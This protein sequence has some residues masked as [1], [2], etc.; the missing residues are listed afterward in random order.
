MVGEL[1][2]QDQSGRDTQPWRLEKLKLEGMS[3]PHHSLPERKVADS[4]AVVFLEGSDRVD[5]LYVCERSAQLYPI[6]SVYVVVVQDDLLRSPRGS[7]WRHIQDQNDAFVLNL[8]N[9]P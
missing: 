4:K 6:V 2:H 9:P 7:G 3:V 8:L 1:G 5:L